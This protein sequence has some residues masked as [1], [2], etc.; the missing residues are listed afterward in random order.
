MCPDGKWSEKGSA[1]CDICEVNFFAELTYAYA[2]VDKLTTAALE[3]R[4]HALGEKLAADEAIRQ[5]DESDEA[6]R[7]ILIPI[8]TVS[9]PIPI[10]IPILTVSKPILIRVRC[11]SASTRRT[12]R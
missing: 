1:S 5:S 7:A 12:P 3:L 9:R 6:K 11:C 8:L 2:A 10:L 4:V